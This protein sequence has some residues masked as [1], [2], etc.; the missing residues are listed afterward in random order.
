MSV[1]LDYE[2]LRARIA[3][4]NVRGTTLEL[5]SRVWPNSTN[6]RSLCVQS[7]LDWM[8]ADIEAGD[9]VDI[10]L[11]I[12]D[13]DAV[14][15]VGRAWDSVLL[16]NILEH[17][18]DP[19]RALENALLLVAPG[20]ACV[21]VGPAIWN[22]H[23]YPRDFWRPLPDFF[24][25]FARRHE[26]ISVDERTMTWLSM[27]RMIPMGDLTVGTQKAIPSRHDAVKLF[28]K[29]RTLRSR[30]AHKLTNS[31]ARELW[32]PYVGLGV[33]LRRAG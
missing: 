20:G 24:L 26:G 29:F 32:F 12:L 6:A 14:R 28:G 15:R 7:G 4:G 10:V 17:V 19:I 23:D 25:E 31:F 5:G 9:G 1:P 30:I 3:D 11:D 33:T 18:Y 13:A 16:M 21:V 2:Y 8:G 22:L 27:E